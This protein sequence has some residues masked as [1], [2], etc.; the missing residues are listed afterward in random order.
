M[1]NLLMFTVLKGIRKC[2]DFALEVNRLVEHQQITTI[3]I[4]G[5]LPV[6]FRTEA[7]TPAFDTWAVRRA[8]SVSFITLLSRTCSS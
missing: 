1:I 5:G 8:S 3:D 7:D 2:V 6:N 4:G